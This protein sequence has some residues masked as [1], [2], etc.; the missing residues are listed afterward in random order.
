MLTFFRSYWKPLLWSVVIFRMC[1]ASS[2]DIPR[3]SWL[4]IPHK[5]KI[6]HFGMYFI[7]CF[8]LVNAFLRLD[9]WRDRTIKVFWV[10]LSLSVVYGGIIEVLQ[11]L[12]F[13]GRSGDVYDFYAN[14]FG[15]LCGMVAFVFAKRVTPRLLPYF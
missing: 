13:V 3:V 6:V 15:A 10:A 7:L 4:N 1:T 8:L 9:V 5:D 14:T 11:H 12:F 2:S